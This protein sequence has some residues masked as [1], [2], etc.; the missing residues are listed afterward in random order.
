MGMMNKETP[1]M[2]ENRLTRRDLLKTACAAA[3]GAAVPYV[4]TSTALGDEKAA[5]ASDRVTIGHIGVGSRGRQLFGPIHALA[6]AQ[7]VAVADCYEDRRDSM[8]KVCKGKAYR[9]FREMLARDDIDAVVIATPDHQHVPIAIMAARAGKSA[10]VEKP[11]GLSIEQDLACLEAFAKA[12]KV[13]QYGTQ[14]RSMPHC[15]LGCELV[16]R[17]AIGKI[18]KIEVD[19]PNG[20]QGGSTA[21]VPVPKGL[22]YDMWLGPA[23]VTPYTVDRCTP[24]GT[25]F[26]YDQSIGYLGGWGAHPLDIMVWGSNADLS[27]PITVEGT[28]VIPKEGLYDVV[29]N[30]DMKIMLG[31]VELVFRPGSDRTK[32]IGADGWIQVARDP[33]NTLASDPAILK[34]T[35]EPDKNE[36]LVSTNHQDNFIQAVKLGDPKAAVSNLVD[37]VRSDI[38]SHL[39]D[40]AVRTGEKI[41]WDPIRDKLVAGSDKARAMLSRPMRAPWTL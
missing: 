27:G 25:Y 16:R 3:A 7:I 21:E 38:I 30:W 37:T 24:P 14:Q 33:N 35:P 6:D 4:I 32:F 31:D 5:P 8:A 26:I 1:V 29:Y 41:A 10:Y 12:K 15:R 2:R 23:P 18:R 9:D 28:G 20:S 22:D 39:S 19:C 17:G 34:T 11:L 40:I 36:L 13:F